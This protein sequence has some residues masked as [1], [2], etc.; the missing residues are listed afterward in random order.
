[1]RAQVSSDD[2]QPHPA[3]DRVVVPAHEP[4][5]QRRPDVGFGHGSIVTVARPDVQVIGA[6]V[7]GLSSPLVLAQAGLLVTAYAGDPPPRTTSAAAGGVRGGPPRGGGGA[8][9]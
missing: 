1:M 9:A 6:G 3:A 8:A 2:V 5:R 7:C 4:V